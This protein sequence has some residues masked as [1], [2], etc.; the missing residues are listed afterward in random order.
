MVFVVVALELIRLRPFESATVEAPSIF[1]QVLV[2]VW[3]QAFVGLPLV[4]FRRGSDYQQ[5]YER[6]PEDR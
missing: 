1:D 6:R 5:S 3:G 4:H 2:V